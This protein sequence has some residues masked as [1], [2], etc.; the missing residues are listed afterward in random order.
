MG[1][2]YARIPQS[3]IDWLSI[4]TPQLVRTCYVDV[5]FLL[6]DIVVINLVLELARQRKEVRILVTYGVR[7]QIWPNFC[8][9][10][11]IKSMGNAETYMQT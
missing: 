5:T 7:R 2:R 6:P 10:V 9:L 8:K 3:E 4:K 11:C 1:D